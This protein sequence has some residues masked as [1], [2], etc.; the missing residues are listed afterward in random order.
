MDKR[1]RV[2]LEAAGF[3][4]GD[5]QDFLGLTDEE[6]RLVELRLSLCR[7]IRRLRQER[8]MTQQQFAK[9]IRSSQSRVAKIEAGLLDVSLDLMF[10]ALF[11][12]GG[13]I[14]DVVPRPKAKGPRSKAKRYVA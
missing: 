10:R 2:A 6:L 12:L 1:K 9:K 14:S 3:R 4:I 8:K 13:K 11:A 5:I 7:A